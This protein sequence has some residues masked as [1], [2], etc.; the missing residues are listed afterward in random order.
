MTWLFVD[1]TEQ[2]S[3]CIVITQK[4]YKA[5]GEKFMHSYHL[6]SDAPEL[7]QA[8]YNAVNISQV[9]CESLSVYIENKKGSVIFVCKI[10][11]ALF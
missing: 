10:T 7:M 2:T 3:T 9:C 6:P 4:E 1:I 11:E 5:N 8:R